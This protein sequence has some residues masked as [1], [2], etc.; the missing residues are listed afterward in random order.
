MI[1]SIFFQILII[2]GFTILVSYV[3]ALLRF[4]IIIAF[5]LSGMLI[6]PN[7]LVLV[8]RGSMIEVMA[9]I[10]LAM[11]L[12]SIGL[13]FDRE[14]VKNVGRF[15]VQGGFLQVSLSIT[16]FTLFFL[17][18]GFHWRVSLFIAFMLSLSS[19][20]L[21][22]RLLKEKH[23]SR[24]LQGNFVTGI[25]LFQD[26]AFVPMLISIPFLVRHEGEGYRS[27]NQLVVFGVILLLMALVMKLFGER[28][29]RY[30]GRL[31]YRELNLLVAVFIPF[32]FAV[33]SHK[34]GFSFALGAFM[35]GALLA[36]SDFHLQIVSDIMPFRDIFNAFFFIAAGMLF[37]W[38]AF[39]SNWFCIGVLILLIL[40]I[41]VTVIFALARGFRFSRSHA[42]MAG[43]FLFQASEF[44]F[45]LANAGWRY[46]LINQGQFNVLFS[47]TIITLMLTPLVVNIGERLL[48]NRS[49]GFEAGTERTRLR[50]HTVI[51]GYGL[52]GRNL[53]MAL[54]KVHIPFLVID[55]NYEN[56]RQMKKEEVPHIF[57]D[58]S[59]EEILEMANIA[60]ATILVLAVSDPG[61]AKIAISKA[62]QKNP[63]LQIIARTRHFSEI[64]NLFRIGASEVIGDEFETSI[65]IFSRALRHYHIPGNVVENIVK[66][67]RNQNYAI[68]RGRTTV[69]M[70]WEKLNALIEAGTVETFLI[71]DE[72]HASGK[73]LS[74]LDL[75]KQTEATVVAVVRAGKSFPSP[76]ADFI[77]QSHD[78]V[79]LTAAHQNLEQAFLFLERGP[80]ALNT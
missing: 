72:M 63:V 13:E 10:G 20:A 3:S 56:S 4:P 21:G 8:S 28:F 79:V 59:S 52:T 58:I 19:S 39:L 75:R 60:E 66:T 25:L 46:Q 18:A 7:G 41:K 40:L 42:I 78:I 76:R 67:I 68:L 73:S 32:A 27:L 12:F 61:A 57:G 80:S 16:F 45:V 70:R 15:F 44:T 49:T 74:E 1:E 9:E 26:I 71:D 55:L 23:Q 77:I 48:A 50:K 36:E 31:N 22:F 64:E 35:A 30:L 14:K 37:Q 54:K 65:E 11:L 24:S 62:R 33:I 29:F 17:L 34:L 6:G 51:A 69:D 38:S 47:T 43:L 53:A 5:I 2:F